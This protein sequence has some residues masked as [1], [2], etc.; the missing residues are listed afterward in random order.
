LLVERRTQ[1]IV[2]AQDGEGKAGQQI[3]GGKIADPGGSRRLEPLD[4]LRDRKLA[5]AAQPRL[6]AVDCQSFPE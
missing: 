6:R 1:G 3:G 4:A 5:A 2:T